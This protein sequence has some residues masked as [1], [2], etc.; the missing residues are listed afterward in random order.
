MKRMMLRSGILIEWDGKTLT[1]TDR[2]GMKIQL[3]PQDQIAL[4][5][6]F[7]Q[8]LEEKN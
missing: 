4:I 7:E 6:F 1:M 3:S 8:M 5:E 2:D